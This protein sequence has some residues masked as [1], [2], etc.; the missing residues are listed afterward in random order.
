MPYFSRFLCTT[1]IPWENEKENGFRNNF[2]YYNTILEHC[3]VEIPL[4]KLVLLKLGTL[5]KIEKYVFFFDILK[6]KNLILKLC[7]SLEWHN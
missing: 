2:L 4:Q 6:M 7:T 3:S 1:V 5:S